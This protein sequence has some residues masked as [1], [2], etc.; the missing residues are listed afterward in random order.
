MTAY[1]YFN[2]KNK[3]TSVE[4]SA[5]NNSEFAIEVSPNPIS[6]SHLNIKING[7]ASSFVTLKIFNL[8][9]EEVFSSSFIGNSYEIG[10]ETLPPGLYVI[11]AQDGIKSARN[12]TIKE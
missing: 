10:I 1:S 6:N 11:M 9:N 4:E 12:L 8:L 3:I 2:V 7:T 5:S